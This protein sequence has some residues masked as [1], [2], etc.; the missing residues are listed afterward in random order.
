MSAL[1]VTKGDTDGTYLPPVALIQESFKIVIFH[2]PAYC[3]R[4]QSSPRKVRQ[5][6]HRQGALLRRSS[7]GLYSHTARFRSYPNPK[8]HQYASTQYW[9][10]PHEDI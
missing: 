4:E 10:I 8:T 5:V 9:G 1:Y 2:F 6:A 7:L 3:G